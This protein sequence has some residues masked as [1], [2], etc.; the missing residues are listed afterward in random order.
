MT[1]LP[2]PVPPRELA[3]LIAGHHPMQVIG[4]DVDGVLAPIV[5]HAGQA[6]L[7][8]GMSN[9]LSELGDCT[10]IAV[11]SGRALADLEH[12][13]RFPSQVEVI[14]SHGLES[15]LHPD[16]RLDPVEEALLRELR[17]CVQRA[18]DQA[19]PGAW[20]EHKPASVVLH[21]RSAARQFADAAA[22]DLVEQALAIRGAHIKQ[23]HEVVEL[24]ARPTSKA[25]AMADLRQ[26]HGAQCMVFFG[27]DLTDEEVFAT[28]G[29]NDIGV[30]IG[31]GPSS[32]RYYLSDPTEVHETLDHLIALL[33]EPLSESVD[34]R[35]TTQNS[36]A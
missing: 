26:R 4:L 19:G 15:R 34:G 21:T 8:P 29:A 31:E 14:G 12:L 23:G 24:M 5:T 1:G 3:A 9:T 35:I 33:S 25:I 27:D 32:A 6:R 22:T 10:P 13:Y 20:C 28:F 36:E 18:V 11:I 16:L 7:L 2:T 30:R 17:V